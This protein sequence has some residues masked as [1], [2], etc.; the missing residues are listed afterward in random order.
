[1][2][3]LG[4]GIGI[5]VWSVLERVLP[6][7]APRHEPSSH[8]VLSKLHTVTVSASDP[9]AISRA[10]AAAQP[11]DTLLVPPG[12][13]LGPLLLKD[14]VTI[15]SM[16]PQSAIVRS[17]P[18]AGDDSGLAVIARHVNGVRVEGMRIEA[19]QTH[20]LRIGVLVSDSSALIC[21]TDIS[22]ALDT[23]VRADGGSRI[24][25]FGNNLHDNP[26]SGVVIKDAAV[27][28]LVGNWVRG[29]GRLPNSLHPGLDFASSERPLLINNVVEQNGDAVPPTR[30][31]R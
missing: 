14:G 12:E 7:S 20:P 5:V 15:E 21:G 27:A 1:L 25:A 29:N 11:G 31:L 23:A 17:D 26:G 28:S 8:E 10:L 30:H 13:F 24:R 9:R 4:I 19:D 16:V 3:L 22:G 18:A 2:L 6:Q